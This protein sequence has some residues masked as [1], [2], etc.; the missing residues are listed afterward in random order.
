MAFYIKV[1]G[2]FPGKHY[3]PGAP[4][5]FQELRKLHEHTF[6]FVAEIQVDHP[7]EIEFLEVAQQITQ[8]LVGEL[9][10]QPY[11]S[12]EEMA[13][14]LFRWLDGG[15]RST[16]AGRVVSTEVNED[17]GCGAV[18]RPDQEIEPPFPYTTVTVLHGK[19]IE[20]PSEGGD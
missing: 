14:A 2:S 13:R 15:W 10:S 20:V 9:Q 3:W 5:R 18:Y 4:E 1:K 11:W 12:C 8:R 6:H 16:P 7:R 17:G 19:A